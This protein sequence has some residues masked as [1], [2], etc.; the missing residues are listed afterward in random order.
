VDCSRVN[1]IFTFTFTTIRVIIRVRRRVFSFEFKF[2]RFL[3]AMIKSSEKCKM[4]IEINMTD[5]EMCDAK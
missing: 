2:L 1:F 5:D 4:F 3:Q